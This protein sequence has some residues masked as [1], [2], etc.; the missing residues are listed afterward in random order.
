VCPSKTTLWRVLTGAD[1]AAVDAA[2]GAWLAEQAAAQAGGP[3]GGGLVAVAVDGKTVRG[4]V[5]AAGNQTHLLAA[6]TH[7]QQLVL[8]QVEVGAKTNEIPMFAPLLDRRAAIG[9]DQV[10]LVITADALH[11]QRAHADYLHERGA[12][13]VA[14]CTA[15]ASAWSK[16]VRTRVAT[17]PCADLGTLVSRLGR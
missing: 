16:M 15:C 4:A 13:F 6:A 7:G 2:V 5:D 1:P 3:D 17:C 12:N 11:C 14:V 8:G 10:R 9:V